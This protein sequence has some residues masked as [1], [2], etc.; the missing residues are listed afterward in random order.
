MIYFTLSQ[1]IKILEKQGYKIKQESVDIYPE[2][3]WQPIEKFY[4]YQVYDK[5]GKKIHFDFQNYDATGQVDRM[6]DK[7]LPEILT[8]IIL[9]NQ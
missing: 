7:I 6:F 1:K 9:K 4:V 2:Y 3:K 8:E 5:F